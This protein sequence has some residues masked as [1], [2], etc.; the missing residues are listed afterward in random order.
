MKKTVELHL[1]CI[2]LP[3]RDKNSF[4]QERCDEKEKCYKRFQV[5]ADKSAET[6][7]DI[8]KNDERDALEELYRNDKAAIAKKMLN[9][10]NQKSMVAALIPII[11][12]LTD[13]DF[14]LCEFNW[15]N[16]ADLTDEVRDAAVKIV[17][18]RRECSG[19]LI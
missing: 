2:H 6:P 10:T 8:M 17:E 13:V 5:K 19:G 4:C 18:E 12:G 11:F 15:E 7:S 14:D 16:L 1:R 9:A 3:T